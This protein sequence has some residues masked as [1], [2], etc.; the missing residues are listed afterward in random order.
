[1]SVYR[2]RL[3]EDR[4]VIKCVRGEIWAEMEIVDSIGFTCAERRK[5]REYLTA[6]IRYYT[7]RVKKNVA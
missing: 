1:M 6:L 5:L 7:E 3:L 4:K 2:I